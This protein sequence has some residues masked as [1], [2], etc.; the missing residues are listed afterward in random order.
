MLLTEAA[1]LLVASVGLFTVLVCA[2]SFSG[3]LVPDGSCFPFSGVAGGLVV[4]GGTGAEGL[5][6]AF[7]GSA[8][9]VAAVGFRTPPGLATVVDGLLVD[10]VSLRSTKGATFGEDAAG[11]KEAED[12]SVL[13]GVA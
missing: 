11:G 8:T 6:T 3:L 9:V 12:A 5:A 13:E 4:L 7:G 2:A 1:S 10:G